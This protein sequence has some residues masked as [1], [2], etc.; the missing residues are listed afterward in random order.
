[1]TRSNLVKWSKRIGLTMLVVAALGNMVGRSSHTGD[2]NEPQPA[3]ATNC[4]NIDWHDPGFTP[5]D[6]NS[7]GFIDCNSDFELGA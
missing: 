7:D 6:S 1:M 2:L 5:I 4:V 3:I